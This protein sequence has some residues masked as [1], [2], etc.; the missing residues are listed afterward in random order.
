MSLT[1]DRWLDGEDDV[2][3]TPPERLPVVIIPQFPTEQGGVRRELD[4][5]DAERY[6]RLIEVLGPNAKPWDPDAVE[7]MD[8]ALAQSSADDWLLAIGNP[9]MIA[10][11]AAALGSIHG[12]I[13]ILQWQSRARRYE[14]VRVVFTENGTEVEQATCLPGAAEE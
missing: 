3:E 7:E 9:T 14:A 5:T 1:R 6:G 13:N 11:A 12:S 10:I 8:Q 2:D 4:L